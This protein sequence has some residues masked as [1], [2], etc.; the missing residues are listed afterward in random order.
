MEREAL[1]QLIQR[2]VMVQMV[3]EETLIPI[4]ISN[5]HLHITEE[6]YNKLFPNEELKVK[7]WLEQPGEFA[8]EQTVTIVGKKGEIGRVRILGPFRKTTQVEIS[9]TD[10]RTLGIN[11][12]IRLS[13]DIA[14]TPEF[15]LKTDAGEVVVEQGIIVAKRHIHMPTKIAE[16]MQIKHGEDVSVQVKTEGRSTIFQDCTVRVS[17]KFELEM[18]IDTDEANAANVTNETV[19]RIVK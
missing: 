16:K 14:G 5:R 8:A 15:K 9:K 11:A 17:D 6:D 1:K 7:K 2:V 4:G 18:H 12:P 19:A 10:A 3:E 13:G